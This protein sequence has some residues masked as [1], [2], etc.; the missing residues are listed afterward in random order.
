MN[1]HI[2]TISCRNDFLDLIYH[3]IPKND[4][5]IWHIARSVNNP[6]LNNII[7]KD[8]RVIIHN[9][10]CEDNDTSFKM[11]YIFD[12]IIHA[13]SD[14]YFCILDDDSIFHEGMYLLYT[15]YKNE[16]FI[17]IGSQEDKKGNMRLQGTLPYECAIDS[18]NVLCH[19]S[20]LKKVKWPSKHWD[21]KIHV[22]FEFWNNCFKYFGLKNTDITNK[23]I[24]VYNAFSDKKDTLN[25]LR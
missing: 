22:D 8:S 6:I 4:D 17:V 11:S 20:V 15:K 14:S 24:S 10:T 9:L 3:S 12:Q 5:I 16:K 25:Y 2:C 13:D 19:S 7:K 18:G 21:D 23:V 1:L